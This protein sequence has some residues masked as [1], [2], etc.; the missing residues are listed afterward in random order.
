MSL[1]LYEIPAEIEKLIDPETGEITDPEQLQQ[2]V[3]R[4]N[5]G[6]EWLALEVKNSRA[7]AKAL[8][9]EKEMF[10]QRQ[11]VAENRAEN[12]KNYLAFL[13]NGEKYK[14]D[15]VAISW[16]RTERVETDDDFMLWAKEQNAFLRWKEPEID[17]T[18]LKEALKSGVQVPYARLEENQ[19][20]I[21]K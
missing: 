6:I 9:H 7:E 14:T 10:E 17:K 16:R 1:K 21:I 12:L 2:L 15:K 4:Y 8:K 3:N 5:N 18:T 11:K 13:L 20:I 19:S